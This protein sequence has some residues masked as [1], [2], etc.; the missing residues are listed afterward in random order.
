M[1]I[2]VSLLPA[3]AAAFMLAFARVGA[4]VMLL[5]GLGESN[6]PTRVKLS[7]A[8]MLTLLKRI[9]ERDAHPARVPGRRRAVARKYARKKASG[10]QR[11]SWCRS[12]AEN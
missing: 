4:M 6:I 5:P 2:D 12:G 11:R 9:R 7:I 8:L 3:L 1:R 10:L